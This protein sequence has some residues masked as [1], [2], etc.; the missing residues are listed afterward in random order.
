MANRRLWYA[1]DIALGLERLSQVRSEACGRVKALEVVAKEFGM[2]MASFKALIHH[3][4]QNGF[5]AYPKR[6]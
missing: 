5:N 2:E 1:E 3:A 6:G 4:R